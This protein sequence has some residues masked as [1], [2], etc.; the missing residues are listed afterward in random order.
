[1]HLPQPRGPKGA[2]QALLC[3]PTALQPPDLGPRLTPPPSQAEASGPLWP[4]LL[5]E[6]IPRRDHILEV[7][8]PHKHPH[9]ESPVL[10]ERG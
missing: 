2:D 7:M 10:Q 5:E 4:L 9:P 1:M 8:L 6:P 3:D